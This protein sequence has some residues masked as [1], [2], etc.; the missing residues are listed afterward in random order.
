LTLI[1]VFLRAPFLTTGE[2]F[3]GIGLFGRG[4]KLVLPS[5]KL[6]CSF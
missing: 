4:A 5:L 2:G 1:G 6:F 3:S